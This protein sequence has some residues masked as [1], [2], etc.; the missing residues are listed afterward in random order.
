MLP[1]LVTIP[2][3][4]GRSYVLSI[5]P[6]EGRLYKVVGQWDNERK[7]FVPYPDMVYPP[8]ELQKIAMYLNRHMK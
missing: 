8:K 6:G 4:N 3:G 7:V 2:Y 1:I 5:L